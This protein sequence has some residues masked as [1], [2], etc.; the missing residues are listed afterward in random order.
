MSCDPFRVAGSHTLMGEREVMS[1]P[2]LQTF[3]CFVL[4][5]N[6]SAGHCFWGVVQDFAVD[7]QHSP[8]TAPAV[9]MGCQ[10]TLSFHQAL[11]HVWLSPVLAEEAECDKQPP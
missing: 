1:C 9:G 8:A 5:E 10:E 7:L 6:A 3:C 4:L 2:V 11:Q